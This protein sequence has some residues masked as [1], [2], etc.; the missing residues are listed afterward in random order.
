MNQRARQG[1]DGE[2]QR[3]KSLEYA[4]KSL[5]LPE[6]EME[7]GREGRPSTRPVSM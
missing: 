6:M 3:W 2:K 4:S 5:T 1:Q 7:Q